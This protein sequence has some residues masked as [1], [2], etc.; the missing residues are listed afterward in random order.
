MSTFSLDDMTTERPAFNRSRNSTNPGNRNRTNG[1]DFGGGNRDNR[2]EMDKIPY[3]ESP[4]VMFYLLSTLVV[5]AVICFLF[6]FSNFIRMPQL[7][8]KSSNFLIFA[9]L[10]INFIHVSYD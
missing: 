8:Q 3:D 4:E 6:V 9:L 2:T 7:R 1:T 10:V 5:P